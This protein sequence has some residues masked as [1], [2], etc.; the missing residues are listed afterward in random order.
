[1][2]VQERRSEERDAAIRECPGTISADRREVIVLHRYQEMKYRQIAD[3]LGIPLGTV[4]SRISR[5]KDELGRC[6]RSRHPDLFER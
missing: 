5:G 1:M 4:K 2:R 3:H 6:L